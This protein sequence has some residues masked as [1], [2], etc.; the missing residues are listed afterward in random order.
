M[1]SERIKEI[2]LTTAYPESHSLQQALLQVWNEVAQESDEKGGQPEDKELL[3]KLV[4]EHW[5]YIEDLLRAH[6]EP[7][8]VIT[9]IKFHYKTAFEHGWKHHKEWYLDQEKI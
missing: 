2:A 9:M 8:D 4:D 7:E 6:D 3:K 5:N 1:T